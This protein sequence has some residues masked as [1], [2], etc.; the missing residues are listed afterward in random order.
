MAEIKPNNSKGLE[1]GDIVQHERGYI[2]RVRAVEYNDADEC[3]VDWWGKE[4]G[5]PASRIS[6]IY[7]TLITNVT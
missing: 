2:G 3:E 1:V 4:A 7:L 6:I 5:T